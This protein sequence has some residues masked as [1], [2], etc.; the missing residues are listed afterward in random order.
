MNKRKIRKALA[1]CLSVLMIGAAV[2][3]AFPVPAY[4]VT[5]S[6]IDELK[7]QRNAIRA[8]R[9]EKQAVVEAL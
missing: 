7:Q 3:E 1:L 8:Q 4:A 9:Q 5:Q 6:Q 2:S